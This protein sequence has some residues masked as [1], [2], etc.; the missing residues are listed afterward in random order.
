MPRP[1]P[2][3]ALHGAVNFSNLIPFDPAVP[4][5]VNDLLVM[6]REA[7]GPNLTARVGDVQ[8]HTGGAVDIA[9][10][11]GGIDTDMLFRVAGVW[12]GTGASGL[13][14]DGVEMTFTND[15]IVMDSGAAIVISGG[16]GIS[17]D[18]GAGIETEDAGSIVIGGT[19]QL[20]GSFATAPA[21]LNV[22]SSASITNIRPNRAD[23]S[24][25]GQSSTSHFSLIAAGTQVARVRNIT[26]AQFQLKPQSS[27]QNSPGEPLLQFHNS[28]L[29]FYSPVANVISMAVLGVQ[30]W[31]FTADA[32]QSAG[33]GAAIRFAS[34]TA[35]I[36]S[37]I[38][39]STDLNTGW[40]SNGSD[41]LSGIAGGIEGVRYTA[42]SG[43]IIHIKQRD[44]GLTAS[45][46]QTQVGALGLNSSYNE[47][48]TV[49]NAND[50]VR[51]PFVQKGTQLKILNNGANVLQVFPSAS[52][53]IGA[54]V[55]A[56]ITIEA[57]G[58]GIFSGRSSSL[59]DALPGGGG[60][61]V[62]Q[63]FVQDGTVATG[64]GLIPIDNTAP[65]ITEGDEYLT[66]TH[67]ALDPGN[68]LYIS[69]S[70]YFEN[71]SQS[72]MTMG[73][74]Q[75]GVSNTLACV[76]ERGDDGDPKFMTLSHRVF[77]GTTAPVIYRM[78]AGADGAG[79]TTF[80]GQGGS[81]FFAGLLAS[82][83]TILE[84]TP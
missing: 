30:K 26:N 42:Q 51:A 27:F 69:V 20:R 71:P 52:D 33:S 80:N 35:V 75:T 43:G 7:G 18:S 77:A 40:G 64:T 9:N 60:K 31:S 19:G 29:G 15:G 37:L 65:Q 78:R 68:F 3:V 63:S 45:T 4:L 62:N 17:L 16:S 46:T 8:A 50:A 28:A 21:L 53:D 11:L 70:G 84:T 5:G 48:A 6:R 47:V 74:F 83:M 34:P 39:R 2:L 61:L 1:K 67:T 41:E 57:G 44:V 81:P 12:T 49:A 24:G 10:L 73:L 32:L 82:N 55:N 38:V 13:K 76:N 79:T 14:Y 66:L 25:L 23:N 72:R 58:I 59:W 54:G 56:S 22:A 36:P